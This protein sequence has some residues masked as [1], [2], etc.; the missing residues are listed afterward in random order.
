MTSVR[1]RPCRWSTGPSRPAHRRSVSI[2]SRRRTASS[3]SPTIEIARE[4]YEALK[5]ADALIISTDWDLFKQP[6]FEKMASLLKDKVIFDGRNL[7]RL[8]QMRTHGYTY[9][10]V[11]RPDV[12]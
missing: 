10:S 2:P 3:R 4:Q 9:Y 6:D 8:E 12:K 7:Y 11:G 1:R 5:D